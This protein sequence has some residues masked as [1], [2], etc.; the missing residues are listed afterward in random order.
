MRLILRVSLLVSLVAGPV[1]ITTDGTPALGAM[2]RPLPA[3]A[4]SRITQVQ[5]L[6]PQVD[7]PLVGF[8]PPSSDGDWLEP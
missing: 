1:A 6:P 3:A 2:V 4:D 5:V 8:K 7:C